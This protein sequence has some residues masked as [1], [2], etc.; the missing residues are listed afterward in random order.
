MGA[1]SSYL[2]DASGFTMS[3][4]N[5]STD[6]PASRVSE[7]AAASRTAESGS[8]RAR[9]SGSTA[10]AP[11]VTESKSGPLPGQAVIAP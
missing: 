9:M 5:G 8:P 6:A 11:E 10:R 7:S 1:D 3:S 4:I 2:P